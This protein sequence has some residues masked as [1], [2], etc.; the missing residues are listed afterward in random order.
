[1]SEINLVDNKWNIGS[2]VSFEGNITNSIKFAID[3]GMYSFQIFL[4]SPQAYDRACISE[5]DI[6]SSAKLLSK[7]PTNLFI[8]TPFL[9]NLCGSVKQLAWEGD[10]KQDSITSKVVNSIQYELEIL[11]KIHTQIKKESNDKVRMGV[12]VHPGNYPDVTKGLEKIAETINMIDF[13]KNTNVK[14][15][16][17]NSSGGGNKLAT[18][19]EQIGTIIKNI[20][21]EKRKYI[22]VCVD[23]AHIYGFGS[24][25]LREIKNVDKL[26]SEFE[27]Y[28][29][30]NYFSLLHLN[31]SS[32]SSTEKR[33]D[34]FLGSKK[35]VH[36]LIGHGYIW[37][38]NV[39]PLIYLLDKCKEI[40]NT[41][42]ILETSPS[43]VQTMHILSCCCK[44]G[45]I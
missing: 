42:I 31:D 44:S 43:D 40:N 9:F 33:K 45:K 15:L 22:G 26:F 8:H 20:H 1:M 32:K 35:D 7:F 37:K 39:K 29:G 5:T 24:Y 23:T 12:V 2:H 27:K 4:G 36:E 11:D 21:P 3:N 41:P 14:L 34:A 6:T 25:D 18:T 28:I 10:S 19:F 16:L 30:I 17:E 38:D 13:P